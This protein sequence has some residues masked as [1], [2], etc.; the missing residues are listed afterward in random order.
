[1]V[2]NEDDLYLDG[3]DITLARMNLNYNWSKHNACSTKPNENAV[4]R[5]I[6]L[7]LKNVRKGGG[8]IF[9]F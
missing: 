3:P 8:I 7:G 9:E 1:M 4:G 2:S 6:L 5:S